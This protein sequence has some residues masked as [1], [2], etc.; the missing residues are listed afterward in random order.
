MPII[1]DGW[2]LIRHDLSGIKEDD[3]LAGARIL[4]SRLENFQ[5]THADSVIVVFDSKSGYL[6]ISYRN[7]EKLKIIAAFDADSHIKNYIEKVPSRQRRNLRV[8]SSDR[9]VYFYAKD[10]G[11]TPIKSEEFWRKL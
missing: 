1:I 8:V 11:A 4:L 5:R 3:A 2:N 10:A 9:R 7:T 6:D